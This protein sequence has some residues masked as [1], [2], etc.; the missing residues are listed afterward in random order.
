VT[1]CTNGA[2]AFVKFSPVLYCCARIFSFKYR[3]KT[4]VQKWTNNARILLFEK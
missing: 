2:S 4:R 1:Y 3:A